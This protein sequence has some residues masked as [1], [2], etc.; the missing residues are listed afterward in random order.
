VLSGGNQMFKLIA[1]LP[2]LVLL[3]V[4]C[5]AWIGVCKL[6]AVVCGGVVIAIDVVLVSAPFGYMMLLFY[7]V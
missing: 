5:V 7:Q 1:P 6:Y 2:C 3:H 4:G